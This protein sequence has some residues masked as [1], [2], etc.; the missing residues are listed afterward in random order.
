MSNFSERTVGSL[1]GI[2]F[3]ITS[4]VLFLGAIGI[5]IW[6]IVDASE[7][8][9]VKN[10]LYGSAFL[11]CTLGLLIYVLCV[12]KAPKISTTI[13]WIAMALGTASFIVGLSLKAS[14]EIEHSAYSGYDF[15][16]VG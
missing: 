5:F 16:L 15:E 9:L 3:L 13:L 11:V 14:P 4:I 12:N 2:I 1:S 7:A 10:I 6:L 8:H